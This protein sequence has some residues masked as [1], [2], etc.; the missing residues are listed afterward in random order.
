MNNNKNESPNNQFWGVKHL[1]NAITCLNLFSGCC[2]VWLAFNGNFVGAT[3]AVI[4][5]AFFDFMDGMVA[6][7]V[8]AYSEMG[9]EL[10]SLAD[11]VSFGLVPGAMIFYML[12][13][14]GNVENYTFLAFLIPIFS[15]LRLAK[16]NIDDRQTTSFIG[17]PTPANAIFW[18]G[19]ALSFSDW[20]SANY[21]VLIGLTALFS[22]LL[23]SEIPMFSLKFKNLSW[24][25]NK[26]QFIFLGVSLLL[27]ILLQLD[28]IAPIILWYI[29]LSIIVAFMQKSAKA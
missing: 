11:V 12:S 13:P 8:N 22:Y 21:L 25:D 9:K 19:I 14:D 3:F 16:F 17:L 28:A 27:I 2:G 23:V 24:K 5:S 18:A 15:A 29:I 6:R 20:F 26:L 10:D 7:L 4:L 1:P